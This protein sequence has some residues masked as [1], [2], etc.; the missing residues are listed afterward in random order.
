MGA[1][2][3]LQSGQYLA[4]DESN[5]ELKLPSFATMNLRS[6]YRLSRRLEFYG[7]VENLFDRRYY[8]YGAFTGLD[9]LPPSLSLTNPRTYS[10]APGRNFF[11][12]LR[13]QFD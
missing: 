10:P 7:E 1:D 3:R 4:G 2:L 6:A 13:A 8:T 9:G 11:V 5:Q 12:G